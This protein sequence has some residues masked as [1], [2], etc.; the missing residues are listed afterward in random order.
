MMP[1]HD[2]IETR[3]VCGACGQEKGL[4]HKG[5]DGEWVT[6]TRTVGA[7]CRTVDVAQALWDTWAALGHDTDGDTG[8]GALIAG[9]GLG[10]F[11][12]MVVEDA[13][14]WREESESDYDA[15]EAER[16]ALRA[17]VEKWQRIAFELEDEREYHAAKHGA[18]AEV[19]DRVR[20]LH[21]GHLHDP[22]GSGEWSGNCLHCEQQWPCETIAILDAA[23]SEPAPAPEAASEGEPLRHNHLTR[24]IKAPGECPACDWAQQVNAESVAA[25]IRLRAE[26][27]EHGVHTSDWCDANGCRCGKCPCSCPP[28]FNKEED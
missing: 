4:F 17:E 11:A 2:G 22:S 15:L 12:R 16:D 10:G 1:Q 13:R 25:N 20:A 19:L 3:I 5:C 24:D 7:W 14:K 18:L 28:A 8:P 21:A 27:D 6:E 26:A 23:L 9:M